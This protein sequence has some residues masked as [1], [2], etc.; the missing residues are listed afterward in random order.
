MCI[1]IEEMPLFDKKWA[2][3]IGESESS[4]FVFALDAFE[5]EYLSRLLKEAGF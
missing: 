5:M 4:S 2:L 3:T 1:E